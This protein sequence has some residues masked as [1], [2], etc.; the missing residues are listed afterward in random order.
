MEDWATEAEIQKFLAGLQ[1]NCCPYC[2]HPKKYAKKEPKRRPRMQCL[3][4]GASFKPTVGT[5][6][7]GTGVDLCK[8]LKL[9][10]WMQ[11]DKDLNPATAAKRIE[12]DPHTSKRMMGILR[13]VSHG[14][15]LTG[16]LLKRTRSGKG[17]V[18]KDSTSGASVSKDSPETPPGG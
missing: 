8:W 15:I 18:K 2:N 17:L 11:L 1:N 4:C 14:D 10:H 16:Q 6:F 9:W 7:H 3:G 13:S 5:I 12:V